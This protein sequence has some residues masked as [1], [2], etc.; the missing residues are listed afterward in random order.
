MYPLHIWN[1]SNHYNFMF[2][3]IYFVF[4]KLSPKLI[5]F[6]R[7][8][9]WMSF[10]STNKFC[11][12]ILILNSQIMFIHKFQSW[13]SYDTYK[14][15]SNLIVRWGRCRPFQFVVIRLDLTYIVDKFT[16]PHEMNFY[17]GKSRQFIFDDKI[18]THNKR[19]FLGKFFFRKRLYIIFVM[20]SSYPKK[21]WKRKSWKTFLLTLLREEVENVG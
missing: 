9:Y 18:D 8:I 19:N 4:S 2:F 21:N 15:W 16:V 11:P 6:R 3:Y 5:N 12:N 10:Y 7:V 17:T 1:T 14:I 13:N 20:I